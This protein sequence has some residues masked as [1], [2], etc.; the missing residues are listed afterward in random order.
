MPGCWQ[1]IL[2]TSGRSVLSGVGGTANSVP[3]VDTGGNCSTSKSLDLPSTEVR[4]L[5]TQQNRRKKEVQELH[6]CTRYY[7]RKT[8]KWSIGLG[9]WSIGIHKQTK[10]VYEVLLLLD[11][12]NHLDTHSRVSCYYF[13]VTIDECDYF[14]S[15]HRGKL[16]CVDN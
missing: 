1:T 16:A 4:L 10:Q 11:E 13:L 6:H 15:N 14:V 7:I 2:S 9:L 5:P 8:L 3:Q 12:S